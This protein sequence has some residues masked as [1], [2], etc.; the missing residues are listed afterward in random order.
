MGL[1]EDTLMSKRLH[2]RAKL[3]GRV[4]E[5]FGWTDQRK[6]QKTLGH[7]TQF[8]LSCIINKYKHS[9]HVCC[10]MSDIYQRYRLIQKIVFR[11]TRVSDPPLR[12]PLCL[13]LLSESGVHRTAWC[14]GE[15][16]IAS[17]TAPF[18]GSRLLWQI[19]KV[20]F[21]P[22]PWPMD[23]SYRPR[24]VTEISLH[25]VVFWM[26]I[27]S[28]RSLSVCVHYVQLDLNSVPERTFSFLL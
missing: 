21:A 12:D 10:H 18:R 16:S 22:V 20:T 25:H 4:L 13:Q 26:Q 15:R 8:C 9:N 23:P 1:P 24:A 14:P 27:C 11:L 5:T 6:E 28:T 2:Y 7:I 3:E 19:H 17:L